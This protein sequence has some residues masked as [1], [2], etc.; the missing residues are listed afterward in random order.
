MA[1]ALIIDDN[2][3]VSRA[4]ESRLTS[5]GFD[6]FD[7]T[8]TEAQALCVAACRPPDLVVI[9][10][11]IS[12]GSPASAADLIAE[13]LFA[14]ILLVS[15]GQCEVRRRIP[16]GVTLDGPFLLSDIESAVAVARRS[17]VT[18]P[19]NHIY[20]HHDPAIPAVST[21]RAA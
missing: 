12:A 16:E 4:I 15:A 3:I 7:H 20:E 2:R 8:W 19:S 9:G 13:R 11:A 17:P 21:A 10:D 18:P 14:P 1:H 6:S 5:L